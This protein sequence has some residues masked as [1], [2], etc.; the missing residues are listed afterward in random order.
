M[1]RHQRWKMGIAV[2]MMLLLLVSCRA[3][4]R[5]DL[6]P[7]SGAPAIP[8][9]IA[10]GA[11][12]EPDLKVY[13]KETKKVKT[14]AF[15]EYIAGVVAAEMDPKWPLEALAAQA[16]LART[17]TLEKIAREGGVP[18]RNAHASTDIE[19]FQAYDASRIND[20]VRDAVRLTR[21]KVAAYNGR[22]IR[23]WFHANSGGKTATAADGLAF[24]KEPTP[25]VVSIDDSISQQTAPAKDRTWTVTFSKAEIA[26]ALQTIGQKPGDFSKVEI[27]EKSNSGRAL[28]LRM[29]KATVSAPEFRLAIG[30]TKLKST[31]IDSI[32]VTG[33]KVT[34]KGKGYGHGVGMSQWGAKGRAEQGAKAEDIINAYFR[35]IEVFKIWD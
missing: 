7:S 35:G 28:T 15:E 20:R 22:Y 3:F 17:F 4:R 31:L 18:S 33:D 19:E 23:A 29:G 5:P 30:S 14:M 26:K 32:V 9:A 8:K 16:I 1:F 21:G 24:E 25:Y 12:Q 34:F 27:V 10:K 11:R 13:I 2:L 6:R